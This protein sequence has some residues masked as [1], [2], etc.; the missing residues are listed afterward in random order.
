MGFLT[1][2][3][4]VYVFW[5]KIRP[6]FLWAQCEKVK[7][8]EKQSEANKQTLKSG[9]PFQHFNEKS[10]ALMENKWLTFISSKLLNYTGN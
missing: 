8:A 9:D 4:S 10:G 5:F 1:I 3:L 6:I 2:W 7:N